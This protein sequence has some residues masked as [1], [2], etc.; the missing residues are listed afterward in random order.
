MIS[1]R[2]PLIQGGLSFE[3]KGFAH[4]KP[5]TPE[6]IRVFGLWWHPKEDSNLRPIA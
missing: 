2:R 1:Y 4:K 3:M 6:K 5:K